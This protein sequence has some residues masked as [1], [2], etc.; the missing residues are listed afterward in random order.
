MYFPVTKYKVMNNKILKGYTLLQ[1][2]SWLFILDDWILM[3]LLKTKYY[4]TYFWIQHQI[5]LGK[6]FYIVLEYFY[7]VNL[8]CRD[9]HHVT[10][11]VR[12]KTGN[13][14]KMYYYLFVNESVRERVH[15]AE[16]YTANS[17]KKLFIL[18][19]SLI[20]IK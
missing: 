13:A 14:R 15:D 5:F 9:F 20:T 19:T 16:R 11:C 1:Y 6:T 3:W 18:N 10:A 8:V 12:D 2:F 4:L 7:L 17:I